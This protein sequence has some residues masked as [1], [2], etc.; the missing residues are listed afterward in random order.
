MA[1][2]GWESSLGEQ[3]PDLRHRDTGRCSQLPGHESHLLLPHPRSSLGIGC[4][5][6]IV[7]WT[8]TREQ[9]TCADQTGLWACQWGIALTDD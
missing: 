2:E 8:Q 6:L 9:L 7:N 1:S 3:E 5:V 4:L